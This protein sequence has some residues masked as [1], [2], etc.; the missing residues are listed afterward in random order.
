[1]KGNRKLSAINPVLSFLAGRMTNAWNDG[2]PDSSIPPT[3]HCGGIII[4]YAVIDTL[5]WMSGISYQHVS[6]CRYVVSFV[7]RIYDIPIL[8]L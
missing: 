2:Q 6:L 1:M 5:T 8:H 7:T 3:T 4:A